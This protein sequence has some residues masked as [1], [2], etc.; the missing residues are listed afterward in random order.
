MIGKNIKAVTNTNTDIKLIVSG[1][2]Y[3]VGKRKAMV[4]S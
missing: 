4:T 3:T 2:G 1:G